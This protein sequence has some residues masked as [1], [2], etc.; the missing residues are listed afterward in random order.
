[1]T[2]QMR[3]RDLTVAFPSSSEWNTVVNGVSFDVMAGET[4]ALVG[5]SGS[6]KSVTAMAVLRLLP[7]GARV[8]GSITFDGEELITGTDKRMRQI[9]GESIAMIFQEPMTALDPVYTIGDLLIEAIR[10]HR[11][12]SKE[13][14]TKRGL[15]LLN[16]VNMPDPDKKMRSYPHQLSGGQRQRAMIAMALSCEPKLL[17][18]DEPTTALDVT[19][20]AE[21]LDL[22]SDLQQ[23]LGM[24]LLLITHDMGVVADIA[25]R[26]IVMRNGQ[27]VED[28][29]VHDLFATPKDSYTKELLAAVPFLGKAELREAH[30]LSPDSEG[31]AV[32]PVL[33]MQ[34]VSV[35]YPGGLLRKG[36]QA[37]T[38]VSMTIGP[39]E[40][41]GLVGESG[42]GKSTI[43]RAIIGLNSI[44]AGTLTVD[45]VAITG[46]D[47]RALRDL[48][49][50]VAFVFQDP[51]ASLNPRVTIGKS[52]TDPLAWRGAVRSVRERRK[53]A[54][55]I[56]DQLHMP[57]SWV[58]R[59]PHEL[60]GG[61]RQRVG[62]G[63][64]I[65][66]NPSLLIADEPTSALD[67]SVQARVLD[68]FA[69]LQHEIGFACLFISHDLSVVESL[70]HR[71]VVLRRGQVV[72]TGPTDSV[73]RKPKEEYTRRLLASAPVPDPVLQRARAAERRTL[74]RS[75]AAVS[76]E[77]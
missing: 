9:R 50:R 76:M 33:R 31:Q 11:P 68:I 58:D 42:S 20:Q 30:H 75:L 65:A 26:V 55:Q 37:V 53:I 15:E 10:A 19:V 5:E 2:A 59:Y 43:G 45:G 40:I 47:R 48:R 41:V 23:R 63:R 39:G 61:Q 3:V 57:A 12:V 24:S 62:I 14:A 72:E 74:N 52:I 22:L 66:V 77:A 35:V 13:A 29:E 56:L 16:L 27:L 17:I 73:L 69:E 38:H 32:E 18:A 36:F 71:V 70:A 67:V 46:K 1:M 51:A 6:G 60:S 7:K 21:I 34:E 8:A 25:D 28:A 49:R 64:A 54:E 44:A 4:L